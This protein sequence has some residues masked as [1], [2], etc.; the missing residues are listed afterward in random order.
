MVTKVDAII[1]KRVQFASAMLDVRLFPRVI[2]SVLFKQQHTTSSHLAD[3]SSTAQHS[4]WRSYPKGYVTYLT[5]ENV[6]FLESMDYDV[7]DASVFLSSVE[8]VL[9]MKPAFASLKPTI[10]RSE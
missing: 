7:L 3:T 8:N 4:H 5:A 9:L 2:A 10:C 1:K 6:L